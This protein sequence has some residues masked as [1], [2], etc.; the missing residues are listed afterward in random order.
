[1][2]DGPTEGGDEKR[3]K[4]WN[5]LTGLIIFYLQEREERRKE[6]KEK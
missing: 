5:N 1:M 6:Q 4:F 2:V 3:E